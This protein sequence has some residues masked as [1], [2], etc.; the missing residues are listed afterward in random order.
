MITIFAK[1]SLLRATGFIIIFTMVFAGDSFA[2]MV[3]LCGGC[4]ASLHR[5]MSANKVIE[6]VAVI[7]K[8]AT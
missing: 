6:I 5:L 1:L 8:H 7:H 4:D 3:L 2:V